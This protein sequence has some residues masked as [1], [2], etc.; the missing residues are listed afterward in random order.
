MFF[1]MVH[2]ASTTYTWI[3]FIDKLVHNV[4][5][6]RPESPNSLVLSPWSNLRH[7]NTRDSIWNGY[8]ISPNVSIKYSFAVKM[9]LR[10]FTWIPG[11]PKKRWIGKGISLRLQTWRHFGYLH[12]T[13]REAYQPKKIPYLVPWRLLKMLETTYMLTIRAQTKGV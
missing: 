4:R 2:Q 7:E 12:V 11:Y 5:V 1:W 3:Y 13:F 10:N 6:I 8:S 9:H